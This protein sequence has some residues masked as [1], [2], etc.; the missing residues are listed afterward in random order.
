ML[1]CSGYDERQRDATTVD[2]NASFASFFF[3]DP[4]GWAPRLLEPEVPC[5]MIR[6]YSAISKRCLPFRHTQQAQ[7]STSAQKN[8]RLAILENADESRLNSHT[9]WEALSTVFQFAGRIR[10]LLKFFSRQLACVLHQDPSHS[11]CLDRASV[12]AEVALLFPRVR[13]IF[14]MIFEGV[15]CPCIKTKF[16]LLIS[17]F[18]LGISS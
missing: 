8:H 17:Q 7:L 5:I 2:E 14:P 16:R 12:S 11:V 3:P 13:R 9:P 18:Y 1:I 6:R 4:S 15:F 10:V